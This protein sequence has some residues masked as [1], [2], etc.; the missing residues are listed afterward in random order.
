MNDTIKLIEK[1]VSVRAYLSEA[2]SEEE[3]EVL[4]AAA[5]AAPSGRNIQPLHF[6][7]T[8]NPKIKKS[9]TDPM[10]EDVFYGAPLVCMISADQTAKWKHIDAGI[11]LQNIVLAAESLG[12]SSVI[13][14][15]VSDLY[16]Q[17]TDRTLANLW[18]FPKGYEYEIGVAIGRAAGGKDPHDRRPQNITVIK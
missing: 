13:I 16:L 14:G 3:L 18:Q 12:L 8:Q 2:V 15:C 1:R 6:S 9:L 7:F 4:K 5:L 10:G 11:A 17:D